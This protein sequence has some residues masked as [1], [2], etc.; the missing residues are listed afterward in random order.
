MKNQLSKPPIAISVFVGLGFVP[1]AVFAI[2]S[3]GMGLLEVTFGSPGDA[4]SGEP[5]QVSLPWLVAGL[6][7]SMGSRR[8]LG[9]GFSDL[10]WSL[11]L[12]FPL[13]QPLQLSQDSRYM[14]SVSKKAS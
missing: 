6:W 14:C 7:G 8:C 10:G 5:W 13:W 2:F 11:V 12:F 3:A 1:L 9:A 4:P